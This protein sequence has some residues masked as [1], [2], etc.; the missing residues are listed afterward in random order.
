MADNGK[1]KHKGGKPRPGYI[2]PD[3]FHISLHFTKAELE[4]VTRRALQDGPNRHAALKRL[5]L[6]YAKS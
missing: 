4:A 1:R 6:D 5:L 3:P 2:R